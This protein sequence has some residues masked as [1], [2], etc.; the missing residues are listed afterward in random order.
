MS[1]IRKETSTW[2]ATLF[3]RVREYGC[4]VTSPPYWLK[5]TTY[6]GLPKEGKT[7]LQDNLD[8]DRFLYDSC[9]ENRVYERWEFQNNTFLVRCKSWTS[10]HLYIRML[11]AKLCNVKVTAL[12]DR[13]SV[14]ELNLVA[15]ESHVLEMAMLHDS[16]QKKYPSCYGP[17]W[18]LED[19]LCTL[20]RVGPERW[21]KVLG[22]KPENYEWIPGIEHWVVC[23]V[24][25][26]FYLAMVMF[27]FF[28][29]EVKK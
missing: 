2:L 17:G 25:V 22:G 5:V 14:P 9:L 23:A 16:I 7:G 20:P 1:P 18:G 15:A 26:C 27:C 4:H 13:V 12:C 10:M 6:W 28:P 8:C 24:G 3:D 19:R 21:S 29:L 11:A